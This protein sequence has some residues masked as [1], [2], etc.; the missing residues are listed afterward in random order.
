MLLQGISSLT[1]FQGENL[2]SNDLDWYPCHWKYLSSLKFDSRSWNPSTLLVLSSSCELY[3][4]KNLVFCI[5]VPHLFWT[6]QSICLKFLQS[7]N[8]RPKEKVTIRVSI[9][10]IKAYF[11]RSVVELSQ[12]NS[13]QLSLNNFLL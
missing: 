9:K 2:I 12:K 3:T 10:Y 11:K 5:F 6:Y 4:L 1:R 7:P 13:F 8:N